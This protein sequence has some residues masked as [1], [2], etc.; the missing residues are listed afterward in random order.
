MELIIASLNSN[1]IAITLTPRN[2]ESEE[3][4]L[5]DWTESEMHSYL[6]ICQKKDGNVRGDAS[7]K[8]AAIRMKVSR[9]SR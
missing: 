4:A 7:N 3:I 5:V 2:K 8:D 6:R 1:F 9:L